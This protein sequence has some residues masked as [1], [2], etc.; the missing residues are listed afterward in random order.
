MDTRKGELI[1]GELSDGQ[2]GRWLVIYK[3]ISIDVTDDI[4]AL[5]AKERKSAAHAVRNELQQ[6]NLDAQRRLEKYSQIVAIVSD[7]LHGPTGATHV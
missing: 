7:E 1:A 4:N 5:L 2:Y 3:N 6:E